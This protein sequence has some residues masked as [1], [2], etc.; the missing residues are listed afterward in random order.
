[1]AVVGLAAGAGAEAGDDD[2]D[3]E[4]VGWAEVGYCRREDGWGAL[5]TVV[6]DSGEEVTEKGQG[7]EHVAVAAAAGARAVAVE[8]K[9]E[10]E[11]VVRGEESRSWTKEKGASA[12]SEGEIGENWSPT[13]K[14]TRTQ[15]E[16]KIGAWGRGTRKRPGV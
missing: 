5:E 6:F 13:P 12:G 11:V 8:S 9:G 10:R 16:T 15:P 14:R 7:K 3:D 4:T 1:M 2:D